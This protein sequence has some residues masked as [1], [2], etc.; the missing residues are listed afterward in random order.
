[1]IF[2]I[3]V[4]MMSYAQGML[5]LPQSELKICNQR[6]FSGPFLKETDEVILT[7][8]VREA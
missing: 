1:M 4:V 8:T 5:E 6:R 3:V 7:G 2:E